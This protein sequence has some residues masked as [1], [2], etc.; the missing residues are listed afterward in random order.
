MS[1][2]LEGRSSNE[3]YTPAQDWPQ[4]GYGDRSIELALA[5]ALHYVHDRL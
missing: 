5:P 1:D 2:L 4:A 3:K